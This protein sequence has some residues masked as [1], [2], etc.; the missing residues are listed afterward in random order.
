MR[1]L[2]KILLT[3]LFILNI[4]ACNY[5]TY[6][7]RSKRNKQ[8]EAPSLMIYDRIVDFRIEQ[9]GWP[10][11]KTDFISKGKKYYEVFEDFP[12]QNTDFKIIDSN[13][14]VFTYS[15]HIKDVRNFEKTEKADLNSYGGSVKFY[16][17]NGKFIWKIKKR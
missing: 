5:I 9:M 7:P 2:L 8:K 13:S 11:S 3:I 17:E 15:Q 6:T 4:V 10:T 1:F 12:Y 14:M 16:K